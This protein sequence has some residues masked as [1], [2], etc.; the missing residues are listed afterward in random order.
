M[1]RIQFTD[2]GYPYIALGSTGSAVCE[3]ESREDGYGAEHVR[4]A[5]LDGGLASL[6]QQNGAECDHHDLWSARHLTSPEGLA[7]I[8]A[9]H[10]QYFAAGAQVATTA[11]Y[12]CSFEKFKANGFD[13]AAT[14]QC[15]RNG[16]TA[17]CRARDEAISQGKLDSALVAGSLGAYGAHLS[18]GSEY[19]GQYA[20]SG[21]VSPEALVDFHFER[22]VVLSST[23][24]CDILA[25][26]TIPVVAEAEALAT[27]A[28]KLKFPCW[29]SFSCSSGT[30]LCSGEP[31]EHAV[32]AVLRSR[33]IVG[34]GINC[35]RPEF[36]SDLLRL[37]Y[38]EIDVA[39]RSHRD[40]RLFCYPNSGEIW[41]GERREW[42]TDSKDGAGHE[43]GKTLSEFCSEWRRL[44][45]TFIGGCCRVGPDD[46]GKISTALKA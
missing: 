15:M 21:A 28:D 32:R 14:E 42:L 2:G 19:T 45:A 29:V 5:V 16:V 40:T 46:I 25:F 3:R 6:L 23:K 43:Q 33:Y 9:A 36:C 10:A 20:L 24:G 7:A 38:H 22:G 17:A 1:P 44:G 30:S 34:L 27:V 41:D 13:R 11:T 18:D 12:Q 8:E 35:S 37:A 31:F 39:Q 4:A 26:E